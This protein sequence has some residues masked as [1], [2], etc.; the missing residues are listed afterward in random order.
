MGQQ[1]LVVVTREGTN[2]LKF[3]YDSDQLTRLMRNIIIVP[4]WMGNSV[5][6]TKV[7][8]AL[9]RQESVKY[10]IPDLALDYIMAHELYG[11]RKERL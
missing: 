4:E 1:G 7:R 9:R 8:R 5:S 3:I 11:Y 10:V 2:P 6:S